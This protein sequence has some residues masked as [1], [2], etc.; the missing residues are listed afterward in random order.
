[1]NSG[2]TMAPAPTL[3]DVARAAGLSRATVSRVVNGG[4]LVSPQS[5]EA[6]NRAIEELGYSPNLAARMLVT[7]RSGVVGVL[8]PETD[9]RVFTDPFFARSVRGALDAF[10]DEDTRVI[11]AMSK[12]GEAPE[13]LLD[14]LVSGR[15][16]GA[17][18][19][20]HHGAGLARAASR[21]NQPVVFVGMPSVPGLLYVDLDQQ[22]AARVATRHLVGRGRTRIATITGPLD[23][24][25]GVARREGFVEAMDDAGLRPIAKVGGD[26]TLEGGATAAERLLARHPRIDGIFAASDAMAAGAIRALTAAGR[27]VPDDVAVVGFD[28]APVAVQ[29]RPQITT[30]TNPAQE[31]ARLAATMVRGL[32][33][34]GPRPDP[35]LFTSELVVRESA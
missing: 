10:P 7:K 21:L 25:V 8:A 4:A 32:L 29:A 24:P 5:R 15:I 34:G 20:S 14:F 28:D 30:M 9:E 2:P 16:D 3:E 23:M 26:F 18:I 1:M 6:V 12:T 17:V 19:V 11:L 27:R 22:A 31:M 13:R 33:A 35:V